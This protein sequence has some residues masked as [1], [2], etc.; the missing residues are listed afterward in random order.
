MSTT[1]FGFMS[2]TDKDFIDSIPD[3]YIKSINF[4][5]E[6]LQFLNGK[7][8]VMNLLFVMKTSSQDGT[9]DHHYQ[10]P[11]ETEAP[12]VTTELTEEDL[13]KI[14]EINAIIATDG[15]T[16]DIISNVF[17]NNIIVD[18]VSPNINIEDL[19]L[20]GFIAGLRVELGTTVEDT[21]LYLDDLPNCIG[22]DP[23][24]FEVITFFDDY[25]SYYAIL[26]SETANDVHVTEV[27]TEN[28]NHYV[29]IPAEVIEKIA[30]EENQSFYIILLI[31]TLIPD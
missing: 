23:S 24:L 1:T 12:V 13:A 18:A 31:S 10:E 6:S 20:A 16:V 11:A 27:S 19:T 26:I 22:N 15:S 7:S 2:K 8:Q 29:T 30:S 4:S 28:N 17:G 21:V 25:S 9:N 5:N 14:N 3:D